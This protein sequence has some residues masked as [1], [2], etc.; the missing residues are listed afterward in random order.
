MPDNPSPPRGKASFALAT[1]AGAWFPSTPAA[2]SQAIE[3]ADARAVA[4]RERLR[5]R[6]WL[7][8]NRALTWDD[9]TNQRRKMAGINPA[10][11][12]TDAEVRA[13][14]VPELGFEAQG[15]TWTIPAL[16][17]HREELQAASQRRRAAG[18]LGGRAS[19]ARRDHP[20]RTGDTRPGRGEEADF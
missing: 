12:M 2:E 20:P 14:L 16:L 1:S 15:D 6:Y 9:I 10:D 18:A 5:H 3:F 11:V 13:V 7:T 4:L 17:L 19:A 8:E